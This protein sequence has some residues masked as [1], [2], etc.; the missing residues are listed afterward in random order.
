MKTSLARILSLA[1]AMFLTVGA[2]A[3]CAKDD[4]P[5]ATDVAD[6]ETVV[7][8]PE[9]VMVE[10]S[11][12]DPYTINKD[13]DGKDV[14]ILIPSDDGTVVMEVAEKTTVETFLSLVKA[15]DG[16]TIKLSDKDGK[17]I[18]DPK[19]VIAKDMTFEVF[20]DGET[21]AKVH[22]TINV[23]TAAQITST[24]KEQQKVESQQAVIASQTGK[25]P[26]AAGTTGSSNP[27]SSPVS[28][29]PA[30]NPGSTAPGSK[31]V[32]KVETPVKE[33]T[34]AL[35]SLWAFEYGASD[36][37]GQVWHSVLS[38]LEKRQ[39][40][41]TEINGL[42]YNTCV[43][44]IVNEVQTG[45]PSADVY[46]ISLV[47]CRHIARRNC[48]VNLWS[49]KGLN[50]K[51]Y[52][53]AVTESC[54]FNGKAFGI[55]FPAMA[56]NPTGVIYNKD[57]VNRYAKGID[58]AK[59]YNDKKWNFDAFREVAAKCTVIDA[60][61]KTAIYG[62]TSNTNIIG[63]A[64]TGNAGGTA[65]MKNGR[66]EATLCGEES[67]K[68]MEWLRSMKKDDKSWD[69]WAS[70]DTCINHFIAGQAAMFCSSFQYYP[71]IAAGADFPCGFVLTPMGP[72]Q[73]NYINGTYDGQVY[74]VPKGIETARGEVIAKWLNGVAGASTR[75]INNAVADIARNGYDKT[76]QEIYK[77]VVTN[78]TPEYSSGVFDSSISS[79][80]DRSV[81]ELN[82]ATPA[83][84]MQSLKSKAQKQCDDY[85][86]PLYN[87]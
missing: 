73:K 36:A 21:T 24:V 6:T 58:I 65:L 44:T 20:A 49:L 2:F 59:L 50:K 41:K 75:L 61:G 13:K 67:I 18:T 64:M 3:A 38:N 68:A 42:D 8:V 28:K 51:A 29:A 35:R 86:A 53:T 79:E 82:H 48:A 23:V 10:V 81:Y 74:M 80:T 27:G 57:I 78:M 66:V 72:D 60:S 84:T 63:M 55:S 83:Q 33:E 11:Q 54:T 19:T 15:K 45:K 43:N 17:E 16:F 52:Q 7:S 5:T 46:H 25:K 30:S 85:Y 32:S 47:Q 12:D 9:D 37:D 34:I 1:L 56:V 87:Q 4:A 39:G 40:I 14:V 22:M 77:W 62:F 71:T 31:P 76:A 69:Y 70:I 26:G